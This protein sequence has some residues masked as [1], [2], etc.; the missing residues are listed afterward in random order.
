MRDVK[1][2]GYHTKHFKSDLENVSPEFF[3][4]T[5]LPWLP[6]SPLQRKIHLALRI[7]D[8]TY[9]SQ[10]SIFPHALNLH[11]TVNGYLPQFCL[12]HCVF[13][14]LY[15]IQC[16]LNCLLVF[17][18]SHITMLLFLLIFF[19]ITIYFCWPLVVPGDDLILEPLSSL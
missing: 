18:H 16:N 17:M 19:F 8:N 5:C 4:L 7:E 10:N 3:I 9:N 2:K 14:V 11:Y 13:N 6:K 1:C 15:F 12:F